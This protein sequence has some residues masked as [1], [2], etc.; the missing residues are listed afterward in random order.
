VECEQRIGKETKSGRREASRTMAVTRSHP[1]F[2]RRLPATQPPPPFSYLSV[3]DTSRVIHALIAKSIPPL[4]ERPGH[5]LRF[6]IFGNSQRPGL[7]FQPCYRRGRLPRVC[8][9]RNCHIRSLP[10]TILLEL[11]L[12]TCLQ[13]GAGPLALERVLV[14]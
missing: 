4:D 9:Q 2:C 11:G 13:S 14:Q 8:A 12:H 1:R 3:T 10:A 5:L 6:I 7:V